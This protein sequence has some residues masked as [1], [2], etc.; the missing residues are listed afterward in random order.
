M[1]L[2]PQ[3][4]RDRLRDNGRA[5]VKGTKAEKDFWPVVKLFNPTG[6]ETWLLTELDPRD[7]DVA[8]GLCDLGNGFPGIRHGAD[9]RTRKFSRTTRYR[10]RA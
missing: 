4:I 3:D 2:L 1:T 9:Q 7:E 8:R 5:K 6:A 10:H